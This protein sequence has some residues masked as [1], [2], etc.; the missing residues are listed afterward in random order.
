MNWFT[1]RLLHVFLSTQ[2]ELKKHLHEVTFPKMLGYLEK[3]LSNNNDGKGWFV[4][5]KVS[6]SRDNQYVL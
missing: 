2:E 1:E 5:D 6:S 4:G 3:L